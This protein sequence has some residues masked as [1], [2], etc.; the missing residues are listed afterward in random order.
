[1]SQYQEAID[2]EMAKLSDEVARLRLM[3][4][5][6][7]LR[8]AHIDGSVGQARSSSEQSSAAHAGQPA[9]HRDPWAVP[10]PLPNSPVAVLPTIFSGVDGT[11]RLFKL[12]LDTYP[13][14]EPP[15]V[16]EAREIVASD[17]E[18]ASHRIAELEAETAKLRKDHEDLQTATRVREN[19]RESS[20]SPD[21]PLRVPPRSSSTPIAAEKLPPRTVVASGAS[22]EMPMT[23]GMGRFGVKKQRQQNLMRKMTARDSEEDS[24]EVR[25]QRRTPVASEKKAVAPSTLDM[26]F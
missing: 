20:Q 19:V 14:L 24:D 25:S 18:R 4:E 3:V 21:L 6:V 16:R 1:M 17:R 7:Q 13:W 15:E 23:L 12:L 11:A 8:Q 5:R 26:E 22:N 9:Y 2:S 10:V